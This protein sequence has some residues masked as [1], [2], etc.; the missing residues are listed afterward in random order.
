MT[1]FAETKDI[2]L[3]EL[4]VGGIP[5]QSYSIQASSAVATPS[6]SWTSLTNILLASSTN[7]WVDPNP[8]TNSARFYRVVP[9]TNS[10]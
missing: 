9:G 7:T 10:P 8:A 3:L 2:S 4:A 6:N 1:A 5:G